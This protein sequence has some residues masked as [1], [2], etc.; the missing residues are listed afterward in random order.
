MPE[1]LFDWERND[2]IDD[3]NARER[4]EA[5]TSQNEGKHYIPKLN[6]GENEKLVQ[7]EK[8]KVDPVHV[9][10]EAKPSMQFGS[11]PEFLLTNEYWKN[12]PSKLSGQKDQQK[13]KLLN[14]VKTDKSAQSSISSKGGKE[15]QHYPS[16]QIKQEK[17]KQIKTEETVKPAHQNA[18]RK[19]IDFGKK[20]EIES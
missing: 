7:L 20:E 8:I 14:T 11:F 17:E 6:E 5:T 15:K 1:Y 3:N 16:Q 13:D 12:D 2:E 19:S 9:H 18:V 10:Q 4:E